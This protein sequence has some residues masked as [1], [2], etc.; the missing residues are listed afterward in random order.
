MINDWSGIGNTGTLVIGAG[1]SQVNVGTCSIGD[2]SAWSNGA[3]GKINSAMSFGG[4][5]DWINT[6]LKITSQTFA[7]SMWVKINSFVDSYFINQSSGSGTGRFVIS[8]TTANGGTISTRIGAI[9]VAAAPYETNKW[10]HLVSTRGS[11]DLLKLYID[12][13]L[14]GSD[15]ISDSFQNLTLEL[16]GS[17]RV[18]NRYF[19]GLI[20]DVRIYNYALTSEQIKQV[21][22][23]GAVNFR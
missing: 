9:A 13:K 1:G 2:T 6:S 11:D 8:T 5:D 22:N 17:S 4:V 23:G 3:T 16:G 15:S 12:G 14:V 18:A 10:Y 19:N 7:V 20:D 21:Y